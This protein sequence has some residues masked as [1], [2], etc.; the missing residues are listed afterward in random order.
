MFGM[1][2]LAIPVAIIKYLQDF[3]DKMMMNNEFGSMVHG[4]E[5][6]WN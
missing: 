2:G 6:Y 4:A 5:Y 1:L 3:Q